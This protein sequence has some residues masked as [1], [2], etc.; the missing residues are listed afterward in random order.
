LLNTLVGKASQQIW[1]LKVSGTMANP[2]IEREAFP[3]VN[4][5]LQQIQAELQEGAT[6][7]APPTAARD[8][9]AP[10]SR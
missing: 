9:F 10:Q 5:V 3:A 7:V 8:L 2:K 1:Q 6:T 4:Q